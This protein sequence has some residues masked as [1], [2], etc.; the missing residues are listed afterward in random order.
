M[1]STHQYGG[2]LFKLGTMAL[3]CKNREKRLLKP[4]D[5]ARAPLEVFSSLRTVGRHASSI[6]LNRKVINLVA[7]KMKIETE[8]LI[9]HRVVKQGRIAELEVRA[10]KTAISTTVQQAD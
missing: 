10:S 6:H 1:V 9:V 2:Q 4:D 3:E 7:K 8:S 5:S